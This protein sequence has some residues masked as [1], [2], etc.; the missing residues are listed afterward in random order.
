MPQ[1]IIFEVSCKSV[2]CIC[3]LY[4]MKGIKTWV[5]VTVLDFSGK[6]RIRSKRGK[7]GIFEP[8]NAITKKNTNP[9]HWI[10]SMFYVM[11]V[12]QKELKVTVFIFQDKLDYAQGTPL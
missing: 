5:K 10:S 2:H 7:W 8:K 3:E 4:L 6:F 1:I 9:V 11:K 12:I